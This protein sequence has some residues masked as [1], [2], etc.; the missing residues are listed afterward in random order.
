MSIARKILMGSSGGKKSTYVDD[1]FSTYLYKGNGNWTTPTPPL[2]TINTGL[3]MSGEG[4]LLWI[5]QRAGTGSSN[6]ILL[7]TVRG[8]N[9]TIKSDSNAAEV[10]VSWGQTFTP[11][12]FTLNNSFNETNA[13]NETYSSWSYR[14]APGFF[15]IVTYTGNNASN[16]QI[17][18]NLG[19]VP[20]CIIIK[21]LGVA[22]NWAVYHREMD[23]TSPA[24]YGI[25]LNSNGP[26]QSGI[27]WWNNTAPTATHFTVGSGGFVNENGETFVA[28]IFAG[29]EST[30]DTARSVDFDGTGDYLITNAS[31]DYAMGTGDFTVEGWFKKSSKTNFGYFFNGP[32]PSSSY[33][34]SVHYYSSYGLAF[35][36]NG[37]T[38]IDTDFQPPNGE[39]GHIALVRNSGTTSLYYNGTLLKSAS[40]NT[41]YT[42]NTFLI[43]GYDSSSYLMIG[44]V[45]NFRIVK[46]TAV[47]TSSF[48]VPTEPLTNIT[49]TK[50]L[51]CQSSTVTTATT[52][53]VTSGGDPTASTNSPFDDP[54]GF[55]F[56]EEGDQ[57]IIKCGS[58]EGV[59]GSPVNFDV[60][61]GWEPQFFMVKNVGLSGANNEWLMWDSMR[62]VAA[63]IHTNDGGN[64]ARLSPTESAG[65]YNGDDQIEFHPTGV[66]VTTPD[67][68][69]NGGSGARLV[70]IAI[71][72]P[73]GYVGKP[74]KAG[75]EVFAMDAGA[76]SSTIPNFDSGFPVDFAFEKT[77]AGG[78]SWSTG[79][80]LIQNR[81]LYINTNTTESAWDKMVFDSNTGWND[82]SSYGSGDQ[83]W[84]WKRHAGLDVVTYVGNDTY[85]KNI[86]HSLGIVPEMMWLKYRG[87]SGFNEDWQVY[88]KGLNGGVNPQ[89]YAIRLDSDGAEYNSSNDWNDTAPTSTHFT[90]G[91]DGRNN[92]NGSS[93]IN[94][95][96]ASVAG[97]SKVGY[98]D[99]SDSPLTIT[100]GFQPRLL[101]VRRINTN[102]SWY[103]IDTVRGWSSGNDPYLR[104]N[105][106]NAQVTNT[107]FGAP[108]STG[109]TLDGNHYMY[110]NAGDKFIYYAHA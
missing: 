94:I 41:N 110:N 67:G 69:V 85:F 80:R 109:F 23:A 4:G 76:G 34:V 93:Y 62:G 13:N 1:V 66:R 58:Y 83:S 6:H 86:P 16:H 79:A 29:G 106:G 3:D 30:A 19:S 89:D 47:Y 56:G 27:N 24:N 5:K 96:F 55:Q 17:A 11:T 45:S 50:L 87:P 102:S 108:T 73:D 42:H 98:Y 100:T 39:W 2:Q 74:A 14:K 92:R 71:R 26:R 9:K 91:S 82:H 75:T 28:Y 37:G 104:L 72:R 54:E 53:T 97:I 36:V 20:G 90:V 95:L 40:D 25:L 84:M 21:C 7:D 15:D 65:E 33:G 43:G 107:D 49:N 51:C 44:S 59:A 88:H 63:Q 38:R 64:D 35:Y 99:G 77:I 22:D 78:N 68:R 81:Y 12:G 18:H 61:I 101:I 8:A 10:T 31:S 32:Y 57:N 70:Y 52:G 46:G 103:M 48:R 105:S 60:E